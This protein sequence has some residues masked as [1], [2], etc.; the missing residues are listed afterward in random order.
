MEKLEK[1]FVL[2]DSSLNSY[3]FRLLTS[4]FMVDEFKKNPIGYYMH[5]R[6][7]GVVLRWDNIQIDGDKI[8]GIPVINT[9]N[10]RGIKTLDEVKNNFLNAASFGS[11]VA[12]ETSDDPALKLPGQAGVTVT[13]WFARECSLVDIPGNFNA[14]VLFN[15]KGESID[16]NFMSGIINLKDPQKD[17]VIEDSLNVD[18]LLKKAVLSKDITVEQADKLKKVYEQSPKNLVSILKDFKQMRVNYLMS[19]DYDQLDKSDMMAE[20]KEKYLQGYQQKY[21]QQ[22]GKQ[23]T[24]FSQDDN[25]KKKNDKAFEDAKKAHSDVNGTIPVFSKDIENLIKF[26]IDNKDLS[27]QNALLMKHINRDHPER[28]KELVSKLPKE[29]VDELM[30]ETWEKLDKSNLLEELKAKYLEG[31]KM[32]YKD[33]FGIDYKA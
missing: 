10:E 16:L 7:G 14:L 1:K 5:D 20:L 3:G 22:F 24:S 26:A 2:G 31:F 18:D 29:R 33:H 12:I 9:S 27:P 11:I 15:E 30:Q 13:K 8:T 17:K 32:K 25:L 19:L 4:G 28:I 21:Y 6:G 23:H